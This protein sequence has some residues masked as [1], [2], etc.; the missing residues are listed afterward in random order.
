M[1]QYIKSNLVEF[2][3]LVA[4]GWLGGSSWEGSTPQD[5]APCDEKTA[6]GGNWRQHQRENPAN[7]DAKIWQNL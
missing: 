4:G 3:N 5:P 1:I 2:R 6:G 7:V